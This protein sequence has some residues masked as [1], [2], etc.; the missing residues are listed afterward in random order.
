MSK[1]HVHTK[2]QILQ[3]LSSKELG[4]PIILNSKENAYLDNDPEKLCRILTH[5]YLQICSMRNVEPD[6][7]EWL[8]P[9]IEEKAIDDANRLKWSDM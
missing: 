8:I 9:A 4:C 5:A 2:I 3:L 7:Y 6:N 1:V